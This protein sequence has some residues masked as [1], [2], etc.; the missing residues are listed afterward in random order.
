MPIVVK[1]KKGDSKDDVLYRFRKLVLE[2]GIVEEAKNRKEF[3]SNSRK[4]YEKNKEKKRKSRKGG[5]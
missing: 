4:K 1:K 5:R 3:V 2:E